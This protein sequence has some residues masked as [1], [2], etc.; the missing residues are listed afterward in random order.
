MDRFSELDALLDHIWEYVHAA[1]RD[2]SHPFRLPTLATAGPDAPN[3][4]T[5]VLRR[6][7]PET[8][9]LAFHSDRRA[10]KIGEIRASDRIA[11]HGW[12]PERSQQIRLHGSA[13]VHVEDEYASEMWEEEAPANKALYVKSPPP[14]TPQDAPNSG[15]PDALDGALAGQ[16]DVTEQDV[17]EGYVNFAAVRT[18]IDEIYFLHLDPEGHYRARFTWNEADGVF[19]GQWVVP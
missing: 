17:A 13:T 14:G 6:V 1:G 18:V 8:R 16:A 19:D 5:V 9:T 11:W 4:R 10:N 3:L 7:S 15:M 2:R 12:D